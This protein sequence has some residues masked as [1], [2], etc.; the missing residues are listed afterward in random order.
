M[1]SRIAVLAGITGAVVA[2]AVAG[3]PA[4]VPQIALGSTVLFHLE[5]ILALFGTYV[6]ILVLAIRGWSGQLPTEVS[7]QGL[8]YAEAAAE[9]TAGGLDRAADEFDELL[10]RVEALEERA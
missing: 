7:A 1:S 4:A 6:A 8:K 9:A 5:R 10:R 2:T 3:S